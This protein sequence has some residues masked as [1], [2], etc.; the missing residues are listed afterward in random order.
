MTQST[1]EPSSVPP[2][3][4]LEVA[5]LEYLWRHPRVSAKDLHADLGSARGISANTVQSTLERLFRKQLLRREKHGHAFYY[6][7]QVPRQQLLVGLINDVLGRF[8]RDT[9]SSLAAFVEAAERLDENALQAL[10]AE[11]IARRER[12]GRH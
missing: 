10:E 11:I 6:S 7:A 4:E 2:L 9:P 8:G 5:V 12:E 3:G 1:N